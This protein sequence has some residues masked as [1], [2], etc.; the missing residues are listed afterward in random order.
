MSSTRPLLLVEDD[1]VLAEMVVSYLSGH[2]IE[3]QVEP[4]G[5]VAIERILAE[6]PAIVILDLG[7]PGADGFE[8]CRRV[9]QEYRGFILVLTAQGDEVD[10][11][12]CLELGA[13][14]FMAKPVRPRLLLA[15]L[16]ALLRRQ[17]HVDQSPRSQVVRVGDLEVFPGRREA[18]FNGAKLDLTTGE[19]DL[20]SY[21]AER[22]GEIVSRQELYE[23]L[24]GI[25]FD[26]LD[27]SIDLRVSRLRSKL[28]ASA[29][30]PELIKSVR[31]VGYLLAVPA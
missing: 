11:I 2:A 14:D 3:V 5:D 25:R 7:L 15:R 26:G 23:E 24:R 16:K 27:R 18:A 8:V 30:D 29:A 22:A 21:L 10:E 1:P 9:R 17:A 31:G 6:R 13:D 20:L 4:R 19:F 12:A 28:E